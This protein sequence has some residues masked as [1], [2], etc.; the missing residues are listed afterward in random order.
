MD[1]ADRPLSTADR[2]AIQELLGRHGHLADERRP[3]DLDQLLTDDAV[4]DLSDF[5]LGVVT[6]LAAITELHRQRPGD[7][8][9]G[10]HVTNVQIDESDGGVAVRS[11]GLSVMADGTAGTCTYH[12]FVVR[13]GR[14]W[15]I[16]HRRIRPARRD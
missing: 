13:T 1:S 4:Y 15:R 12:D 7:Q 9:I 2:L 11:K 10:H 16:A 14:G 5:G 3:E 6:G 8:P